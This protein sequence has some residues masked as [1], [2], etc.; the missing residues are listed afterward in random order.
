MNVPLH[1]SKGINE[2]MLSCGRCGADTDDKVLLGANEYKGK[3]PK[4]GTL[5]IGISNVG[6]AECPICKEFQTFKEIEIIRDDEKIKG[7]VLCPLCQ[8]A[9][10][11]MREMVEKGGV[12]YRCTDCG[13]SGAIKA[14]HLISIQ[15]RA[16]LQKPAPIPC[17]VNFN[18]T[19]CPHCQ[20]I[21]N[22]NG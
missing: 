8:Q 16:K 13:A 19:T 9:L 22:P 20:L 21:A 1:P 6:W 17:A 5:C 2:R 12:Y 7:Q 11:T 15:V 10:N 14:S 3:C 18:K 4:C